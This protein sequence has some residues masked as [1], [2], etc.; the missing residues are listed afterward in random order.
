MATRLASLH[1]KINF[2]GGLPKGKSEISLD[3]NL[4]HYGELL[5]TGSHG[6]DNYHCNRVLDL[7][8]S[9]KIELKPLVTNKFP[10]SQIEQ[11]LV[12]ASEGKG[13]KTIICPDKN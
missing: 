3:T 7:M 1:G 9:G 6:S 5:I 13:L 10:L 8:V 11:A 2:F 12:A 4:I